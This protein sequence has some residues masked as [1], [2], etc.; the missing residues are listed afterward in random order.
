MLQGHCT[1]SDV[2]YHMS[3]SV[4]AERC[5]EQQSFYLSPE[6]KKLHWKCSIAK[7]SSSCGRHE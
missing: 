1:N 7:C 2:T 6:R 3:A 4:I 5:L